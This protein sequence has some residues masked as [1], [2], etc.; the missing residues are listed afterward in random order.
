LFCDRK[1]STASAQ[2]FTLWQ[3]VIPEITRRDHSIIACSR[4]IYMCVALC[5]HP[6]CGE[7]HFQRNI[8]REVATTSPPVCS[9]PHLS[10]ILFVKV[11]PGIVFTCWSKHHFVATG[12]PRRQ[13][14]KIL[15]CGTKQQWRSHVVL[16]LFLLV[17]DTY[18]WVLFFA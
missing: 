1:A 6:T 2:S 13:V 4:H 3:Q 15:H 11:A 14:C 9:E 10:H 16:I 18:I 17:C 8:N 12:K 7:S 5:A